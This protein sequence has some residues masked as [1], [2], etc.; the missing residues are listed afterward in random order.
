VS[1]TSNGI[2]EEL[3]LE[4]DLNKGMIEWNSLNEHYIY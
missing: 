1:L 4:I 3:Y 2:N